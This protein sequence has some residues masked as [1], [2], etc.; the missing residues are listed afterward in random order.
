[1]LT[2]FVRW[3][4]GS[5][6]ER[7]FHR[8]DDVLPWAREAGADAVTVCEFITPSEV[9]DETDHQ[10]LVVVEQYTKEDL[11]GLPSADA[12]AP[13]GKKKRNR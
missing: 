13:S 3:P 6:S 5:R 2:T 7:A 8:L 9:T 1:M 10:T 11:V 12:E 4:D